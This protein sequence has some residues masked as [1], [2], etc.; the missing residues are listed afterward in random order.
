MVRHHPKSFIFNIPIYFCNVIIVLT[1]PN[2]TLGPLG[3]GSGNSVF[4]FPVYSKGEYCVFCILGCTL[5][6]EGNVERRNFQYI[7]NCPL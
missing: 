1:N 5:V 3:K 2:Y 6:Q 4:T 7:T